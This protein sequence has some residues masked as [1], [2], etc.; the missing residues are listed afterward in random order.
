MWGAAIFANI[1]AADNFLF[2]ISPDS[3]SSWMCGKEVAHAVAKNKRIVTILYHP[4]DAKDLFPGIA[5]F[6]GSII[7]SSDSRRRSNG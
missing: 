2:V 7:R 5:R 1:E 4:I 6:N 3:L